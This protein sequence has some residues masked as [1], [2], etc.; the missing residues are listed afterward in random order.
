MSYATRAKWI[1]PLSFS[2]SMI[3]AFW[4]TLKH[5]FLFMNTLDSVSAGRR[6][7]T[8][9]VAA[10]NSQVPHS[11]FRGQ[12]PDEIYFSTGVEVPLSLEAARKRAQRARR[13]ANRGT[14][15]GAC[16]GL[17]PPTTETREVA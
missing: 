15:C 11:A 16:R 1:P 17:A 2:N 5:Q 8:F 6:L 14:D 7:V 10:Y 4:R 3:E 13:A 12:T 9:Y